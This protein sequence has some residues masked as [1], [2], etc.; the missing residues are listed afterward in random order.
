MTAELRFRVVGTPGPQG[1]KTAFVNKKTGRAQMKESSAKV[2]P[3]R[4]DVVAAA[5]KAAVEQD[6][7]P[8]REI[9]VVAVFT[10]RRPQHHYRTGKFSHELRPNA[11]VW[12][13]NKPDLDKLARSTLDALTT[14]AVIGDDAHVCDLHP[15][16]I[17]A[18]AGEAIGAYIVITAPADH[19]T[20]EGDTAL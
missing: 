20:I 11:P 1:S 18:N 19:P 10:F 4:Q 7:H 5:A 14:A 2:T 13:T 12:H 17:W 15:M 3:W 6:W 16:K 8:P 9:R